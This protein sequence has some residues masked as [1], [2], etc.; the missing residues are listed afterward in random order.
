MSLQVDTVFV[1]V[2]DLEQA[3]EW[4]S[5][6]GFEP[7]ER[8]GPWQVMNV[9]GDVAFALHQGIREEG[10]A[11]AVISFLIDDLE[12]EIDR[13]SDLYIEPSDPEITD[14]GTARF[15]TFTDPDGNEIQLL[16]RP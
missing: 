8:Y 14:S 9:E 5:A 3:L 6:L 10:P 2:N 12:G 4:Y 16:E 1:W 11:T 15:I 7:G 13:L